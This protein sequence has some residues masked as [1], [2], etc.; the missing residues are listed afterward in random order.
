MLGEILQNYPF[1]LTNLFVSIQ[2]EQGVFIDVEGRLN[3]L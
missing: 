1:L 3:E 2:I